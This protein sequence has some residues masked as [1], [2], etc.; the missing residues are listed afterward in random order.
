[1]S[2][3]HLGIA[4]ERIGIHGRHRAA[5][6]QRVQ[7]DDRVADMKGRARPL[8]LVEPVDAADQEVRP[9]TADVPAECGDGAVG[10]HQ[11][12]QHV[13]SIAVVRFLHP[14]IVARRFLDQRERGRTVPGMS[15]DAGARVRAEGTPQ[16]EQTVVAARRA[17]PFRAADPD[18]AIAGDAV[19]PE[20]GA[21]Q[22]LAAS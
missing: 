11:E 9:E 19:E 13:E 21:G 22:P 5:P 20:S 18:D 17:H 3:Q 4:L 15:S 14:G 8:A 7:A 16:P 12:R 2:F 6:S 10:R 1:M